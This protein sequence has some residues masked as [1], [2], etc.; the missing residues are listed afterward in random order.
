MFGHAPPSVLVTMASYA[1]G[2]RLLCISGVQSDLWRQLRSAALS[3]SSR[4]LSLCVTVA[5]HAGEAYN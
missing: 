3:F 2:R 5:I 4:P 1:G